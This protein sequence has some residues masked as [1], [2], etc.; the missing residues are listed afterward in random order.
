MADGPN[1][2]VSN[3]KDE[4]KQVLVPSLEEQQNKN[5]QGIF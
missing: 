5:I 3:E 1:C 2:T 4:W